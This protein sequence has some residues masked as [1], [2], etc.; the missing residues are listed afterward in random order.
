[1]MVLS[2]TPDKTMVSIKTRS[3]WS[4]SRSRFESRPGGDLCVRWKIAGVAGIMLLFYVFG[5]NLLFPSLTINQENV[6]SE[7]RA[8]NRM[9]FERKERN[10]KSNGE[11]LRLLTEKSEDVFTHGKVTI[12]QLDIL[13]ENGGGSMHGNDVTIRQDGLS[14]P[15]LL[16]VKSSGG[17]SGNIAHPRV[18]TL[19]SLHTEKCRNKTVIP[20][21]G[22]TGKEWS[23]ASRTWWKSFGSRVSK[24]R[25][26]RGGSEFEVPDMKQVMILRSQKERKTNDVTIVTQLSL[27]RLDMLHQQCSLWPGSIAAVIYVPLVHGN[28]FSPIESHWQGAPLDQMVEEVF[29][30]HEASSS[31]ACNLDIEVVAEERCSVELAAMY[32]TNSVRNR[33]LLLALTDLILLLDVDFIVSVSLMDELQNNETYRKTLLLLEGHNALVL[34]AFEAW[35]EGEW[36]KRLSREAVKEGKPYIVQKFM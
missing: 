31:W 23:I 34:P 17:I 15:L 3:P 1:M 18:S 28:I 16:P 4:A 12:E 29:E 10:K 21:R 7:S 2:H 25:W 26:C 36:G 33:A 11:P 24:Y 22:K 14:N 5:T 30:F 13:S 27:E 8:D 32:P 19:H 35:D 9:L 20:Y 6:L